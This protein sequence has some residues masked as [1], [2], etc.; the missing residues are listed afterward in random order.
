MAEKMVLIIRGKLQTNGENYTAS[1]FTICN[2]LID[3]TT[4]KA[5]PIQTWTGLDR[6]RG[7][8]DV[9]TPR[10]RNSWH[11]EVRLSALRTGR[12][13]PQQIFQLLISIRG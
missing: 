9:E 3:I 12:F 11:M 2:S 13:Y 6:P 5:F 10:F 8:Q 4:N 1:I 7:L